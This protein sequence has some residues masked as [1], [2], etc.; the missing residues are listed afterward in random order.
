MA[1]Q[2]A[3]RMVQSGQIGQDGENGI[4]RLNVLINHFWT[5]QLDASCVIV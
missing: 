1:G 2:A 5:G 3:Y 4:A